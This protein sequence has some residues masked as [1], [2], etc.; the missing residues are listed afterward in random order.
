RLRRLW[1][2]RGVAS[3]SS[4]FPS[5]SGCSAGRSTGPPRLKATRHHKAMTPS[6]P[7]CYRP[8]TPSGRP[9]SN[10]RSEP[11]PDLVP[12]VL[13][14][15]DDATVSDV[16]VAYLERAGLEAVQASDGAGALA[17]AQAVP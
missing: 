17:Q 13:G 4:E 12:R 11:Y 7:G 5:C 9:V 2:W 10:P 1:R 14:V 15:D 16:V 3:G 8:V 6:L